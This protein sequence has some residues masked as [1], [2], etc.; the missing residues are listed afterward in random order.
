MDDFGV[1]ADFAL[2]SGYGYTH[3]PA[4]GPKV[5]GRPGSDSGTFLPDVPRMEDYTPVER[6]ELEQSALG[7]AL[8]H[9]PM[10]LYGAATGQPDGIVVASSDTLA[11]YAQREATVAGMI[12]AGR[13]HLGSNGAPMLFL[14]LQDANGLIDVVLFSDAYKRHSETL[15][16][17]GHGPYLVSGQVQVAGAGRGI[18]VQPSLGLL[19]VV[20]TNMKLHPVLIAT[21]VRP[22]SAAQAT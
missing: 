14:T 21:A 3:L 11:R 7:F 16:S 2:P 10:E 20:P 9:N 15:A 4:G 13:R 6:L 5:L 12:V 8:S 22:L 18:G 17:G 19:N 1:T